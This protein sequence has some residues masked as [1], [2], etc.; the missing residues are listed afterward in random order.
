MGLREIFERTRPTGDAVREDAVFT[1]FLEGLDPGR[2]IEAEG[3]GEAW[4]A[5]RRL[6]VTELRRRNLWTLPPAC[7]G[8]YGSSS[9]NDDEAVEELVADAFLFIFGERLRPLKAQ[10]RFKPEVEGL[11]LRSARNF[12][13]EA[14]KRYD[15]VGFR[16]FTVLRA[17]VRAAVEAGEL[18]A[19][20][21]SPAVKRGT[22]LAFTG[23]GPT[24]REEDPAAAD[25]LAATVRTWNDALLPDLIVARGWEV[26]PL[27]ARVREHL[28]RLPLL[29]F[30]V[31]RFQD[32]VDPLRRDAGARWR[33][34]QTESEEL[35]ALAVPAR[36]LEERESFRRLLDCIDRKIEAL[37]QRARSKEYLRRLQIFLRHHAVETARGTGGAQP[38]GG[39]PS[40][41]RLADL[42]DVPRE[43]LPGLFATLQQLAAVC[44]RSSER[45]MP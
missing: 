18:R 25:R 14:Q 24:T 23:G 27:M 34:L 36:N 4:E 22:V 1:R 26:R 45:E 41:R 16:V 42:L 2:P 13:Y 19:I 28:L 33:A 7:L 37:A 6:L 30:S 21:G 15:P 5:L 39:L 9:W 11:V 3:F 44:R 29:G 17:A 43:R 32:L 40:H 38:G 12:L 31:F 20:A 10:L 35:D 8:V